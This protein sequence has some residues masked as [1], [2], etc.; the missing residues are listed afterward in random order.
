[1]EEKERSSLKVKLF[2]L[3]IAIFLVFSVLVSRLW[4]LQIAK[5]SEYVA[6]AKGNTFRYVSIPAPRGDIVDDKGRIFVTSLPQFAITLD[7]LDLQSAKGMDPKQVVKTLAGYIQHYWGNGKES[8]DMVAEDIMAKVQMHQFQRYEPVVLM[9]NI[10]LQLRAVLAEHQQELPGISVEPR[11]FRYYPMQTVAGHIL[12]YVR[13]VTSS[14][15]KGF[16]DRAVQAGLSS[17][18]YESGDLVGQMG[19]ENS[20]D[21][22]LRGQDG[23]QLMEVDNQARPVDRLTRQDPVVGKTVQLTI[24]AD[25]QKT[26]SDA[27]DSVIANL[28]KNEGQAKAG[29]GSAVLIDVKTG[30]VLAMVSRPAMNPNDLTGNIP[31]DVYQRYFG[32]QPGGTPGVAWDRAFQSVYAPGSTFKMITAMAALQD[33]K[34]GPFETI[35]DGPSSLSHPKSSVGDWNA[36]SFGRVNLFM[37]LGESIN[38]YFEA[39]GERVMAANPER[40]AQVAREFGLGRVSGIDIPGES[41]GTA[42]SAT[43]KLQLNGPRLEKARDQQ[44]E[45]AQQ[46]YND[47]MAKATTASQRQAAQNWYAQEKA[48]IMFNFNQNYKYG[49]EWQWYDTYNTSIGQGDNKYSALQLANYV[50]TIVNGG[51]HMKPYLVDKVTD[52][53]TGKVVLQNNPSEL[54]QVDISPQN[55]DYVKQAMRQVVT[56]G[57]GVGVFKDIPGFTGGAKTGTAQLGSRG[58]TGAE[59]YNGVFVAFTPYD[60]PQIAFAAVVGYGIHGNSSGGQVA[61]AAFKEYYQ[62]H[63]MM[64]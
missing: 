6:E 18:T 64:K 24:D 60:N 13:E 48:K 19:V 53:N 8:V 7:W 38:Y 20:Y 61:A 15:L 36:A 11:P 35:Y 56:A 31:D 10:P 55:L 32:S 43:W 58:T 27:L 37:G 5:G 52:P 54:N 29:E 28:Q 30:K 63:G 34:V 9:E 62:E 14:E 4:N 21:L 16:Q 23:V 39:L 26:V 33:G 59:E 42:P 3:G 17:D 41:S 12:G 25:L 1:M 46:K 22:Y 57:T 47:M 50:A 44:L 45:Q 49:A 40:L 2:L 51:H